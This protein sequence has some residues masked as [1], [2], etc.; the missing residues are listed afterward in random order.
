MCYVLSLGLIGETLE[1]GKHGVVGPVITGA[2]VVDKS[3][4]N[5]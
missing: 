3:K 4:N 2:R 5:R 1:G